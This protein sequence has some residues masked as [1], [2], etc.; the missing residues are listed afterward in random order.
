[1]PTPSQK[2]PDCNKKMT[3]DPILSI[4]GKA[5]LTFW[6]IPCSQIIVEKRFNVKDAVSSVKR[7]VFQGHLP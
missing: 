2:C 3:Y 4:K 1:M 6:C 7:Y 5:V